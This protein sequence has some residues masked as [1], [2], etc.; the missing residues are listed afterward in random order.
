[1]SSSD[2]ADDGLE[3]PAGDPPAHDRPDD[4]LTGGATDRPSGG[5]RA[6]ATHADGRPL[7]PGLGRRGLSLLVGPIIALV[8]CSNLGNAF[9]PTLST[10]YPAILISLNAANRNLILASGQL[11]FLVYFLIGTIRLLIPDIFFYLLGYYYGDGAIVWMERRTPRFGAMMRQLEDLFA[12][13]GHAFVLIIPNNP[14]CLIAGA[15]HMR[16]R[17][18][19]TLN[20]VGTIGRVLLMLWFGVIFQDAIDSILAFIA[21]YRLPL[22]V[23]SFGLVAFMFWRESRGGT[24][25]IQQL[26]ELE[27]EL[28]ESSDGGGG[29][30]GTGDP[31]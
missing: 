27:D 20:V 10:E 19:W 6:A 1:L 5:A 18:F 7:H 11:P 22:T 21:D 23:V 14:V 2:D 26:L 16:P 17:V 12:R 25:E 3:Q 8:V 24:S 28:E 9:F 30:S 13:F 4:A 15:A 31:S 29:T